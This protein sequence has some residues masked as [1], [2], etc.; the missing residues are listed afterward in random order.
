MN[1]DDLAEALASGTIFGAGLDVITG[2]PNIGADHPLVKAKNCEPFRGTRRSLLDMET[3]VV[4]PHLG[5]GSFDSREAMAS[6]CK[7]G[8]W[9]LADGV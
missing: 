9:S 5:S 3:G 8:I 1:S 7:S 2:E 6:L 4:I